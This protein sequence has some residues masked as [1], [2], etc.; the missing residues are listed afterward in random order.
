MKSERFGRIPHSICVYEGGF[1]G[2]TFLSQRNRLDF[3]WGVAV[4]RS[5]IGD[6]R[7]IYRN[8]SPMDCRHTID[9]NVIGSP[10]ASCVGKTTTIM[11]RGGLFSPLGSRDHK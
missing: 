1:F 3:G 2:L 6:E 8:L 9:G 4:A 10:Y 5:S 11:I 7:A